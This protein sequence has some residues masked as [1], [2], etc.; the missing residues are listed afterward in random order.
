MTVADQ[1]AAGVDWNLEIDLAADVF[2]AHLRQRGRAALRQLGAF[3]GLGQ[4]EDFVGARS[5]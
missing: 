2:A 3:A 1:T 4:A 5:R